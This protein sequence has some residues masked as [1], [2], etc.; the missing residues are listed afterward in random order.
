VVIK[1]DV[2]KSVKRDNL[3]LY[4]D[5]NVGLRKVPDGLL[6]QFGEPQIALSFELS[7]ERALAREDPRQVL[8]N[9]VDK[10]YHLQ[11]PP[12]PDRY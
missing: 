11:L 1:C 9:L 4:V 7:E 12:V 8:K 10:G 3:F 6:D 5:Q 2:Y